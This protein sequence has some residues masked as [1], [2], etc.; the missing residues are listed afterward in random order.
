MT[1]VRSELPISSD[2]QTVARS[3]FASLQWRRESAKMVMRTNNT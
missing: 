1:S 3:M 2:V